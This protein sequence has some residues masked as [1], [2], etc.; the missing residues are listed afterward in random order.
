M[1]STVIAGPS[2]INSW[3]LTGL[4]NSNTGMLNAM[5]HI[6]SNRNIEPKIKQKRLILCC[7]NFENRPDVKRHSGIIIQSKFNIRYIL[8][9]VFL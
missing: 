8:F 4:L 7:F 3:L 2:I 6:D 1:Q 5:L 9:T